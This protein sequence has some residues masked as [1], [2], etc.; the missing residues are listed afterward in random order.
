[1]LTTSAR[2]PQHTV[3]I[4]VSHNATQLFDV[5]NSYTNYLRK[6][7]VLSTVTRRD[8]LAVIMRYITLSSESF[9][10]GENTILLVLF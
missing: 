4:N 1:M 10:K 7:I 5:Q 2:F 3:I 8:S 6:L 9:I